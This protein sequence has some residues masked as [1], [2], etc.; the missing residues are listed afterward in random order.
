M[1]VLEGVGKSYPDGTVAVADLSFEVA[2]GELVCLVG[3]SGCGKTT[4]L[5]MINRLVEPTAGRILVAGEDVRAVDP[6]RLRRRIGYVIQQVGLFPHLTVRANV[7]TVPRLLRW[8]R[9]KA[10][11]RADELLELVGLDPGVVG[12]R[13]PSEL[14]G[15]Q[16]QR[17]G[18]A[19]AL[20]ADPPVLLMDEPFSAIDPIARERLQDEFARLRREISKTIVFV[21]HD[22]DEAIRLADRVAVFRATDDGGRLEQ[23]DTPAGILARPATDFVADFTGA[24]RT[25]RRLD[26]TTLRLADL[27]PPLVPVAAGVGSAPA[28]AGLAQADPGQADPGRDGADSGRPVVVGARLSDAL[29]ALLAR[30]DARLPVYHGPDGGQAVGTS[31]PS[32]AGYLTP[33]SLHAALRRGADVSV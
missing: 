28:Q 29:T 19:R 16:Q 17:V 5:K 27:E 18:V 1:I 8:N 30:D 33:A 22:I 14:S 24:E 6:V 7:A 15:G 13:Y 23:I 12:G 2:A 3:P 9:A 20:A 10:R 25:L 32:L 26:V 4:T 21:T 31:N 11:A